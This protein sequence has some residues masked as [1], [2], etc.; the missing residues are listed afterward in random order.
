MK[1][2]RVAVLVRIIAP[3]FVAGLETND[4]V[5]IRAAPILNYMLGWGG[6]KVAR[7]CD[8]KRWRWEIV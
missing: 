6:R 5:V 8:A 4:G 1:R 7:Y 2:G 3:H